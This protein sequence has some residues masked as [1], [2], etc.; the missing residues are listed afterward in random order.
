LNPIYPLGL[1]DLW[2]GAKIVGGVVA[3]AAVV[4]N[5]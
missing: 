3:G 4:R 2:S 1:G 5:W